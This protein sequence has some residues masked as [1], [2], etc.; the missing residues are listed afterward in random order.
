MDY[1]QLVWL[2]EHNRILIEHNRTLMEYESNQS[3]R[4]HLFWVRLI[5]LIEF[6]SVDYIRLNSIKFHNPKIRLI[7][8]CVCSGLRIFVC[9]LSV[10]S[11]EIIFQLEERQRKEAKERETACVEWKTKVKIWISH[12]TLT[13]R[14]CLVE[15]YFSPF[16]P[17]FPFHTPSNH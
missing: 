2:F 17:V 7:T 5:R 11:I 15:F 12:V 1:I 9:L 14:H 4:K 16:W 13:Q 3:I 8:P 10:A 6:K